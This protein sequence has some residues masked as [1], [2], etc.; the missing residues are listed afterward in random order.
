MEDIITKDGCF[1]YRWY[2]SIFGKKGCDVCNLKGDEYC[3]LNCTKD[4]CYMILSF[5]EMKSERLTDDMKKNG[6]LDKWLKR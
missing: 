5:D 1:K 6:I 2:D 3:P 4:G